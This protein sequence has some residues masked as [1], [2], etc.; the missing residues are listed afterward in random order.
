MHGWRWLAVSGGI[1]FGVACGG[2]DR[3]T[4]SPVDTQGTAPEMGASGGSSNTGSSGEPMPP[5]TPNSEP[6]DMPPEQTPPASPGTSNSEWRPDGNR[7]AALYD[8]RSSLGTPGEPSG[9]GGSLG[10][11]GRSGTGGSG[12]RLPLPGR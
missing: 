8:A 2:S 1:F 7:L 10:T 4:E 11:G 5:S 9:A 12:G 3:H 6:N